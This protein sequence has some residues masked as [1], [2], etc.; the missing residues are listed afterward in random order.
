MVNFRRKFKDTEV[1]TDFMV[2]EHDTPVLL[3]V[4]GCIALNLIKRV[5]TVFTSVDTPKNK[6]DAFKGLGSF[7]EPCSI[8]TVEGAKPPS[9]LPTKVANA[10]KA[11]LKKELDRLVHR[12]S[13]VKVEQF[14]SR[15]WINKIVLTEKANKKVRLCLDPSDLN[16]YVVRLG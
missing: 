4:S 7:P 16:K 2:V 13:I 1:Y 10:L 14:Y 12:N 6:F 15:V 11:P 8:P 3:S 9:W 5:N